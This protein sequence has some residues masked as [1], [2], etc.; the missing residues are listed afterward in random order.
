MTGAQSIGQ[1]IYEQ[2]AAEAQAAEAGGESS[3]GDDVV[4]AEIID[5]EGDGAE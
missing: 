3:E 5:E 1:M 2:A 4:E